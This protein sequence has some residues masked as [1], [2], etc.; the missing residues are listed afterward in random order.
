MSGG[1]GP[2]LGVRLLEALAE[3]APEVERHLVAS[4]AAL[5]TL[6]IEHPERSWSEVQALAT[7]VHDHRD[8]GAAP[9]SGSFRMEAMV[10]IPASMNT[11]AS[12]AQGL[13]SNLLTRSADV[14]LKERRN[15]V[16]VP[17]ETPLHLGHL[18]TLATLAE[19]G[20]CVVPPM[21]AF[22]QRP[23]SLEDMIDHVVGKVLDQLRLDHD[24]YERWQGG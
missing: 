5:R 15:L 19:L 23:K 20:A 11:C 12:I 24:L 14:F 1:S 8:I 21:L 16:V 10:V 7:T 6:K 13:A 4:P 17:R 9:A 18:R 22:Y 3:V 2:I